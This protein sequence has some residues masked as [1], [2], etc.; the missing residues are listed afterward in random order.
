MKL[1]QVNEDPVQQLPHSGITAKN[2]FVRFEL[3]D[4]VAK[5]LVC[6]KETVKR[7]GPCACGLICDV[8]L[9]QWDQ[10]C[11]KTIAGRYEYGGSPTSSRN[12]IGPFK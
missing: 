11:V 7:I 9:C 3:R 10:F 4:L 1:Q 8:V 6:V 12:L 2:A 5:S